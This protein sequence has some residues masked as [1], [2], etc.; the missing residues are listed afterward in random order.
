MDNNLSVNL[1]LTFTAY[2]VMRMPR[3]VTIGTASLQSGVPEWRLRAW[4]AAGLL[5]PVRSA[6]GYRLFDE[7]AIER[8][9]Q[10]LTELDAGGRLATMTLAHANAL[11]TAPL[12]QDTSPSKEF[13]ATRSARE[14]ELV[15]SI[16]HQLQSA[17]DTQ[18]AAGDVIAALVEFVG[19][20][21][22]TLNL[23]DRVRQKIEVYSSYGLSPKFASYLDSWRLGEGFGGQ[24]Y[25]LREPV[26]VSDLL[27]SGK[28]GR[29]MIV[30]EGLRAYACVPLSQG[31]RRVGLM[32]LYRRTPDPF[33]VEDI[34][35]LEIISAV[36]TPYIETHALDVKLQNLHRERARHFRTLVSLFSATQVRQ[37]ELQSTQMLALAA[38]FEAER[39]I[40]GMAAAERLRVL[41]PYTAKLNDTQ[42]DLLE[43]MRTGIIAR[44]EREADL[45]CSLSVGTW[46][47]TLSTSHASRLY[48]LLLRIAEELSAVTATYLSV[49]VDSSA[50][51]LWIEFTYDVAGRQ[52]DAP[53]APGPEA[54]EI[55]GELRGTLGTNQSAKCSRVNVLLPRR[56]GGQLEDLLTRR[57][58]QILEA[59]GTGRSNKNIA[60]QF[61]ISTKTLQNHLTSIYRKLQVANRSEAVAFLDL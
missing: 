48:L 29:E 15:R 45:Q 35:L 30:S 16:T 46:P 2:S 26:K 39:R 36:I 1:H 33:S 43:L 38:E 19:A 49:Y 28:Y 9:R 13:S 57:E 11:G 51:E 4:E 18:R 31:S 17:D 22:A 32:E 60:G 44:F 6:A 12:T 7:F 56:V 27:V 34:A 8:A 40:G 10:L 14:L 50:D 23:A 52:S 24:A 41:A 5:T 54:I 42:F 25:A 37:R 55:I 53:Y 61:E 58:R 59:L 47:T 3:F 21:A 20:D